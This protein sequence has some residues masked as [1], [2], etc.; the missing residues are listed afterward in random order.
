[1]IGEGVLHPRHLPGQATSAT[2][3][4][5]LSQE[6]K[7]DHIHLLKKRVMVYYNLKKNDRM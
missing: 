3:A 1:M 5:N 6:Q 2:N 4:T 7:E